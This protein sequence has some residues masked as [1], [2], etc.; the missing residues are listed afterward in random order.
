[1]PT[2]QSCSEK[3]TSIGGRYKTTWRMRLF[4]ASETLGKQNTIQHRTKHSNFECQHSKTPAKS[5]IM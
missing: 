5:Q 3:A 1:M 4:N 2:L